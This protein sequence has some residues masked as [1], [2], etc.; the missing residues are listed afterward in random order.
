M[1]A[2]WRRRPAPWRENPATAVGFVGGLLAAQ[3]GEAVH[4]TA[5]G[6]DLGLGFGERAARAASRLMASA[7]AR[8]APV[9]AVSSS[10]RAAST[11]ASTRR[12]RCWRLRRAIR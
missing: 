4:L 10:L 5:V 11:L 12:R 6:G 8:G 1:A 2:S 3:R 9:E 7:A